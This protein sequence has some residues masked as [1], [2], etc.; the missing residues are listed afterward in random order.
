M[1][2][3]CEIETGLIVPGLQHMSIALEQ[4]ATHMHPRL[5]DCHRKV[6]QKKVFVFPTPR[7]AGQLRCDCRE[8]P[9]TQRTR[10]MEPAKPVVS[11]LM[12]V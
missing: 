8:L 7:E 12:G 3:V 2:A 1:A 10:L 4:Q 9:S 6:D 5:S 11:Y